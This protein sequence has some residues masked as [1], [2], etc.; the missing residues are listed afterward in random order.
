VDHGPDRDEESLENALE[1]LRE[2]YW[3]RAPADV[4]DA[5]RRS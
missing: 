2:S 1:W 4:R 3:L 5:A